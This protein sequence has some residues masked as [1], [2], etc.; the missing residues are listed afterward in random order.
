M[1]VLLCLPALLFLDLPSWGGTFSPGRMV[2]ANKRAHRIWIGSG[3]LRH[4]AGQ[5]QDAA[6]GLWNY[7][8]E[9]SEQGPTV[10]RYHT[11]ASGEGLAVFNNKIV[12]AYT[13]D[14][15]CGSPSKG[16]S[17]YIAIFDLTLSRWNAAT[18]LGTVHSDNL[19]E[20]SG[21]GAAVTLFNGQ[22]YAFTDSGTY[23]S[24]D[25]VAWAYHPPLHDKNHQPLDAVTIYPANTSPRILIAY[26]YQSEYGNYFGRIGAANWNGGFGTASSYQY[27][28]VLSQWV[29]GRV[30]LMP[31]TKAAVTGAFTAGSKSPAVQLFAQTQSN[32]AIRNLEYAYSGAGGNWR[33]DPYQ[34]P[35]T[36]ALIV[37]PWFEL[38]SDPDNAEHKAQKQRFVAIGVSSGSFAMDSDYMVP[39]NGPVGMGT[40]TSS[41]IGTATEDPK[42]NYWSLAG[43][44]LGTPPFARNGAVTALEMDPVSN[45]VYGTSESTKVENSQQWTNQTFYSAGTEV[46]TGLFDEALKIKTSFDVGFKHEYDSEHST[47]TSSTTGTNKAMGTTLWVPPAC[48]PSSTGTT[49]DP[50]PLGQYGW[51]LFLTP[52]LLVQD[53]RIYAYDYNVAGGSGTSLDQNLHS[54]E[55]NPQGLSLYAARFVLSDPGGENQSIFL[56]DDEAGLMKGM[57]KFKPSI[58]LDFWQTPSDLETGLPWNWEKDVRWKTI[59]G[60]G[61]NGEPLVDLLQSPTSHTESWFKETT[62]NLDV[63]G[64]T[65]SVELKS[66]TQIEVQIGLVGIGLSF[67]AGRDSSFSSKLKTSTSLENKVRMDLKL[68][69]CREA[70]CMES[71]IVRP[72]LLKALSADAPWIPDA[73]KSQRPW[74]ITW[75]VDQATPFPAEG[76]TEESVT[77]GLAPAPVNASGRIVS[78]NGG[79]GGGEP[80]SHYSIEGGRMEWVNGNGGAGRIPMTAAQFDPS[81]GVRLDLNGLLWSSSPG[82]GTWKRN[83][84]TWTFDSSA[85]VP[86]NRVTLKLDFGSARYDLRISQ[87]AM[88]GRLSA[89]AAH[90]RLVLTV[91]QKYTFYNTLEHDFDIDWR[92]NRTPA[93]AMALH[94]ASLEGRYNSAAQTGK[95]SLSGT[96]PLELP[97]FGDVEVNVN[98][99]PYVAN[100]IN[101]ADFLQTFE[102]GGVLRHTKEGANLVV[103]FGKKTW[104]ADFN[105]N[106]FRELFSPRAGKL[107]T[108][109]LV[110]GLPWQSLE[111]T[112]LDYSVNLK[113]RR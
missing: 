74:C 59:F 17:A 25:G 19:G 81:K 54:V 34:Y 2:Y 35:N 46:H 92:W 102:T 20:G 22:L 3:Y 44:I 106:A 52:T 100:L 77:S 47:A 80:Y 111:H 7:V 101:D 29:A 67:T 75:Q 6:N 88:N 56:K 96:L 13:R 42:K 62:E 41:A 31:G 49:C 78:G 86:H 11:V 68:K 63:E 58:D 50:D 87:A 73:Y 30:S 93:D 27:S 105:G 24:G 36:T 89:G 109:I 53:F 71:V 39:M 38:V 48:R 40:N 69:D 4:S 55:A 112:V 28:D 43:V 110:G 60:D 12:V 16:M 33:L 70:G 103:D 104:S 82:Q 84:D 98:D 8:A 23:T 79:N 113:M 108:R 64:E 76:I 107:R 72:Y 14:T 1:S 32:N 97:A 61:T 51:A 99:H 91:N 9:T 94:V 26:G 10:C 85:N 65:T 57:K 15:D 66:T 37:Y 95:V 18:R 45:V 83:G 90:I 21:S 5:P